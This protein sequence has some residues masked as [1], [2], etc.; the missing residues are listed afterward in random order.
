MIGVTLFIL[1]TPISS[2]QIQGPNLTDDAR[3]A[4]ASADDKAAT[5]EGRQAALKELLQAAELFRASKER[6]EA[7]RVF[8][9]IGRLQLLLNDPE[10]ALAS[11]QTALRLL[12]AKPNTQVEV[13]ALNGVA[14]AHIRLQKL[15]DAEPI[16][17]R[18]LRQSKD[19]QYEAG[20]AQALLSLSEVQNYQ[21]HVEG[22]RT[23]RTALAISRKTYC[24]KRLSIIRTPCNSGET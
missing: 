18:A 23:A 15:H 10:A 5:L 14:A 17:R 11:H 13:D 3:R 12:N 24:Q 21:D 16:L 2:R 9:R 7:A 1:V 19:S 4:A 20:R 6:T 22:L 8:N